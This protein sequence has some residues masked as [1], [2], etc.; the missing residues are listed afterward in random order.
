MLTV[1][2]K[3]NLMNL[4]RRN[5]CF[6]I[7]IL[8]ESV[9]GKF[10]TKEVLNYYLANYQKRKIELTS[11]AQARYLA[12][13][14]ILL[15]DMKMRFLPLSKEE[16][17]ELYM[18]FEEARQNENLDCEGNINRSKEFLEKIK[19]MDKEEEIPKENLN[20]VPLKTPVIK[21]EHKEK[22][23]HPSLEDEYKRQLQAL[24]KELEIQKRMN[25]EQEEKNL[26]LEE[27]LQKEKHQNEVHK[28]MLDNKDYQICLEKNAQKNLQEENKMWQRKI[29]ALEQD[30][31]KFSQL[32]KSYQELSFKYKDS[33]SEE[34]R[35]QEELLKQKEFIQA[36]E[37]KTHEENWNEALQEV[38]FKDD[39]ANLLYKNLL[40]KVSLV[41]LQNKL[42]MEGIFYSLEDIQAFFEKMAKHYTLRIEKGFKPTYE[43]Q[44][45][46]FPTDQVFTLENH[47]VLKLIF[48]SDYH[49]RKIDKMQQNQIDNLYNYC[50][51]NNIRTI[52]NLGDFYSFWDKKPT[53]SEVENILDDT[54]KNYPK[55]D[56]I[57]QGILI[58]NHD[59]PLIGGKRTL[60][61]METISK[62]RS[63]L[64]SL[65]WQHAHLN[66]GSSFVGI[67]HVPRRFIYD[68]NDL[69]QLY[70]YTKDYYES[71]NN[72]THESVL[73]CFG[74]FHIDCLS[75][76]RNILSVPSFFKDRVQNGFYELDFY[77]NS[78]NQ[79]ETIIFKPF[80]VQNGN[81]I[82]KEEIYQPVLKKD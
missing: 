57:Q 13:F 31:S 43:L 3:M 49:L 70:R 51:Q 8:K 74:H 11:N 60:D 71:D 26:R 10:D 55:D 34:K 40:T 36:L 68:K 80:I 41:D 35:K 23:T 79:I 16:K 44:E 50:H 29:N 65:G 76:D 75:F 38:H 21:K 53:F 27:E 32:K 12:V 4:V 54:I 69:S 25:K 22:V 63:D 20:V 37:Q 66:I 67:H 46:Y 73:D 15:Y 62:E 18:I 56:E 59:R 61:L 19:V 9:K 72:V 24:K 5:I 58:G 6:D 77:L 1:M 78:L 7:D 30:L 28:K 39:E 47:G 48:V 17:E 52:I 14:N 45:A 33:Q 2:D 64:I 82:K 42:R 81:F